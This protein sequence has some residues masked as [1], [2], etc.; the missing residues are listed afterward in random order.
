MGSAISRVRWPV[1]ACFDRIRIPLAGGATM[2]LLLYGPGSAL[3]WHVD[4][5]ST[6]ENQPGS[7]VT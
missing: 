1:T 4:A 2:E 5:S 7:D 6:S 3:G